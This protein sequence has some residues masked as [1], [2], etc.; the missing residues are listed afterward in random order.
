MFYAYYRYSRR[1]RVHIVPGHLDLM[2]TSG[3]KEPT[4]A[5]CGWVAPTYASTLQ[6]TNPHPDMAVCSHCQREVGREEG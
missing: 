5:L 1:S 2:D 6:L 3:I 4:S